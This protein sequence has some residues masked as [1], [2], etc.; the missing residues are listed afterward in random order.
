MRTHTLIHARDEARNQ[1]ECAVYYNKIAVCEKEGCRGR[2][3]PLPEE[4]DLTVLGEQMLEED[5]H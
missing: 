4:V 2:V 1:N 3:S 5:E